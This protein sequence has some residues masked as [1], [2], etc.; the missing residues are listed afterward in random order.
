[1]TKIAGDQPWSVQS[2]IPGITWPAVPA[3][4]AATVLAVL[5]Q[6][7]QSQ[8]LSPGA[9]QSLQLRQTDGLL[10]HAYATVDWYRARWKGIYDP[11]ATLTYERFAALPLLTRRALQDGFDDLRSKRIPEA[12]G[13]AAEQRTSG[14]TGAP[15][16][17]LST[18]LSSLYWNA[19]TLRD[20]LWHR[21]DFGKKLAVIRRESEHGKASNWGA[22]TSGVVA[23]GPSVGH[24]IRA[25][26][27]TLL[28]WLATE[29]P[30]YL[31]TYPSLV[32]ELARL[33]LSRGAALPGL[34]EVRTFAESLGPDV[35]SLCNDA[36]G[37]PLTDLYS[38]TETGYMAL[39]CPEHRHYHVQ[40]EG[41]LL[42]VLDD[43]GSPCRPGQV[44]RIV[45]TSLHNFAM[46]LIRYDIGDY[47][48][49]GP[50]CACGRGLPVLTRILGRVRNTLITA[51]GKRYWPVFGTRALMD[52]APVRQYQFVQKTPNR[53]EARLV[54]AS[55]LTAAQESLFRE[56]VM[57]QLPP[58]IDVQIVY[59]ERLERSA[60]GKYEEFY[61]EVATA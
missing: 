55:P 37:V 52:S 1:M 11:N 46:P 6:L 60:G 32:T 59:C 30:G 40:A 45:V 22:A 21:R 33:S 3:P 56:R 20:H 28:D 7:E 16:R 27:A 9:L 57:S 18:R 44:G 36:W 24:S 31:F 17:L 23:T 48:E 38:A 19:F 15:V 2:S 26:A 14:S 4:G 41:V 61:S 53:I 35:R 5:H 13:Q 10:R 50:P 49:V 8:W 51:D 25:D 42:E 29:R 12:H 47:A 39:Q 58:G 34:V 43:S 54:A